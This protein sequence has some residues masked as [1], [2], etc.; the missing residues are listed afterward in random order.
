MERN[1]CRRP[2]EIIADNVQQELVCA[3]KI[4]RNETDDQGSEKVK[5]TLVARLGK[6]AFHG[7][8]IQLL[9]I[10]FAN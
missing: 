7:C 6:L 10:D 1:C 2:W 4:L 8:A 9:S 3:L 5:P